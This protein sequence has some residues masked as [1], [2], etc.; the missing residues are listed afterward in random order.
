MT[1]SELIDAIAGRGE[2]TKA[3]AELVVNTVFDAMIEA[4][5]QGEG[6]EIRGFGSFTMRPYKPYSGRNPR[7]GQ[8]VSVPAKRLPFFKVG[9]ELKE[10]VNQSRA[11]A[12]SGGKDD[13]E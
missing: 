2:L 7:T 5:E 1:K 3:R 6:I 11:F 8:A 10:L 4:L 9:K 13:D 12:I